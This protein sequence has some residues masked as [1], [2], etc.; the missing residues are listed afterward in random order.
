MS[1]IK[2]KINNPISNISLIMHNSDTFYHDS[3]SYAKQGR[4]NAYQVSSLF[5]CNFIAVAHPIDN[6]RI[7]GLSLLIRSNISRVVLK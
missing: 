5:Y 1:N 2:K 6:Q 3:F 4:A 7:S